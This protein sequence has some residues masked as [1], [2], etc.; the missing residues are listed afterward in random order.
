MNISENNVLDIL[1]ENGGISTSYGEVKNRSPFFK[2]TGIIV[3]S[4]I[5]ATAISASFLYNHMHND[6][7]NTIQKNINRST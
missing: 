7:G 6:T 2:K 3:T 1:K 5:V 4:S